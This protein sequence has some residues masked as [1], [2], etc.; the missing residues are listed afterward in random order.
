MGASRWSAAAAALLLAMA[1]VGCGGSGATTVTY[2]PT[3]TWQAAAGAPG[4]TTA[5][6]PG[7]SQYRDPSYG[8]VIGFPTNASIN[9]GP[10][11]GATRLVSWRLA[12]QPGGADE[13]TLEV[14]AT[15]QANASLC[16]H[17]TAGTTVA[18]ADGVTGYQQD[19]LAAATSANGSGQPQVVLVVVHK[20]LLSIITLS[21][22]TPANTFMQRWGSVWSHVL[23]TFQ[24]GQGPAGAKPCG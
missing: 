10:Q 1:L 3:P 5:T 15:T 4:V 24:P 11:Q 14:T 13:A 20:G 12:S 19:N 17:Y 2:A 9:E 6:T 18:L 7:W 22:S 8:F 21:G 16:A 23:A